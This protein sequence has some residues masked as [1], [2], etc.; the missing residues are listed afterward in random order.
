[1]NFLKQLWEG[2][3]KI[4]LKIAHVQGNI[5]L[6]IIYFVVVMPIA[7]LFRMTQDPLSVKRVKKTSY[8]T[9]RPET[10]PVDQFLKREY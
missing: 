6:S 8:W 2:W 10:G 3:K 9:P 1:M 5:L 4:A 7:L